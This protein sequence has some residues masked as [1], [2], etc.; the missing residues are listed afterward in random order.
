[1]TQAMAQSPFSVGSSRNHNQS[2][3]QRFQFLAIGLSILFGD[4]SP[5]PERE[6]NNAR[7][8]SSINPEDR[9]AFFV[10]SNQVGKGERSSANYRDKHGVESTRP[11][12]LLA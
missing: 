12:G 10:Q 9:R 3:S 8:L 5:G 4:G 2:L 7:R 11:F 6:E 1:M